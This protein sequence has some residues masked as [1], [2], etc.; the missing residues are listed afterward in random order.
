M[1][2]L[3]N[4]FFHRGPIREAQF[5]YNR[6]DETARVLT[7]LDNIQNV[8]IVGQRRIGKTSLLLHVSRSETYVA[9]GLPKETS[10]FVYVDSQELGELDETQTR[11]FMAR[12]L[13][14][15]LPEVIDPEELSLTLSHHDFR[16][17]IEQLTT[18][19]FKTFLLLDEFEALAANPALTPRFFSGLRALSSQFNLAFVTASRLSLFDLTYTREDTLSSP[20]FNTFAHISLGLFTEDL[21][22]GMIKTLARNVGLSLPSN[23]IH[24]IVKVAGPHP[25]F[26]QLAAFHACET[27]DETGEASSLWEQHFEA[28]AIPHFKYYWTHLSTEEQFAL[29]ALP[30]NREAENQILNALGEA[31]LTRRDSNGWTYLSQVFE[32]FVRRQTVPNLLQLGSLVLD[33]A[34]RQATGSGGSLKVTKTEFDALALLIRNAGRVVSPQELE[35]AL[36]GDEYIEDPERVRAVIKSLRK[37]L[38]EDAEYLTTKWG[39]GYTMQA[40]G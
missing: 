24:Q 21:A 27:L 4:P 23:I 22:G 29:A 12:Q 8:A 34:G 35:N 17:L 30:F 13:A 3:V 26:L 7:L 19:G 16:G 1:P 15:A 2:F 28:E 9:H 36:W 40:L 6:E 11:G 38:S 18:S 31:A 25:F 37:A 20:F 5:F 14:T 33:L 10:V 39:K 32:R